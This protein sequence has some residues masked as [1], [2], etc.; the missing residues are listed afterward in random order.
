LGRGYCGLFINMK[1][2]ADTRQ[3]TPMNDWWWWS[4]ESSSSATPFSGEFLISIHLSC[5]NTELIVLFFVISCS[6]ALSSLSGFWTFIGKML[7]LNLTESHLNPAQIQRKSARKWYNNERWLWFVQF[8]WVTFC[9]VD[10][11]RGKSASNILL[12]PASF[13]IAVSQV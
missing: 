3:S 4:F 5:V 11:F 9:I 7:W 2:K 10:F 12:S 13:K 1:Q 6:L 8:W